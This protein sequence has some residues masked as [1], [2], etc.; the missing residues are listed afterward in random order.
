MTTV[1]QNHETKVQ[2]S[3]LYGLL[4]S[5]NGFI[6]IHDLDGIELAKQYLDMISKRILED[7]KI[8]EVVLLV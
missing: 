8:I 1:K 7:M 6:E 2:N 5:P 3:K 4:D